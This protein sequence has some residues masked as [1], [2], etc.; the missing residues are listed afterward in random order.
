MRAVTI[1]DGTLKFQEHPDPRPG[2]G[3]LLV[4]VRAAG[5]NASDL[6]QVRGGYPAPPGAPADIPGLELAGQVESTGPGATRFRA[7]DRVMA[8][9]GGGGQSERAVIHERE[10]MP[11]PAGLTWEQAGGL[12]EAF[13]TA[14]DALFTQ[15]GL[16]LGERVCVHGAAGGVGTAGVQLA[17]AAGASVV[18]TVRNAGLRSAVAALGATVVEPHETASRGPYD[19]ILE[20]IGA[21]NMPANFEALAIGG[22]ITV[23]GVGGGAVADLDLRMLMIKRARMSGSTLR[24][25]P[26]EQKAAAARA[27]EASVLPLFESGRLTVPVAATFPLERAAE[28][29]ERFAA[30]GK[31]GKVVLTV[32]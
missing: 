29:Y 27:V 31:F 17:A 3:Q 10:A 9:V 32:P 2:P 30:G 13:T 11:V 5:I 16:T 14:H 28:G 24:P 25:R 12:P 8:V 21:P 23:I 15:C 6:M 18:A 1:V 22:R 20:L 4:A 26:L 7:G 19:V